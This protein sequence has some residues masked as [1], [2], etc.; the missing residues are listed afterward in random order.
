M[1]SAAFAGGADW[2]LL[3]AHFLAMSMLAIGGAVAVGAAIRKNVR[4][5]VRDR[6]LLPPLG[7]AAGPW[8]RGGGSHR[9]GLIG[10]VGPTGGEVVLEAENEHG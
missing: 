5:H 9:A 8:V 2:W 10:L 6:L 3:F 4:R 1:S 7:L